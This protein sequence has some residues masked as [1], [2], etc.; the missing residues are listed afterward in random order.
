MK[1]ETL[2]QRV[3]NTPAVLLCEEC[4]KQ[5]CCK[6]VD[7]MRTVVVTAD[8]SCYGRPFKPSAWTCQLYLEAEREQLYDPNVQAEEGLKQWKPDYHVQD[9][10]D[11]EF[12]SAVVGRLTNDTK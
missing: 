11:E 9:I 12:A 5:D 10:S 1:L 2:E 8:K 6:W 4:I 3:A 7:D